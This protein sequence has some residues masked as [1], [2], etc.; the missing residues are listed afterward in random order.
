M[1]SGPIEHSKRYMSR[2]QVVPSIFTCCCTETIPHNYRQPPLTM[3]PSRVDIEKL[4]SHLATSDQSP[5]FDR[6]S[7]NV[8]WDVMGKTSSSS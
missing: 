6:V 1:L 4:C 5:F 8:V 3:A 2:I 7:P